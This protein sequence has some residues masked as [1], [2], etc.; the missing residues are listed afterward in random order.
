MIK[1]KKIKV[2]KD[3]Y[4]WIIV[5]KKKLVIIIDP[6]ESELL[7]SYL[8][9]KKYFPVAVFLTHK[10]LDHTA[11]VLDLLKKF[12]KLTIYG[13]KEIN[14]LKFIN[15]VEENK[16]INLFDRKWKVIHTPGHTIGHISY[17]SDPFLFCGDVLFSGGCGKVDDKNYLFLFNSIKKISFLPGET[18][19]YSSHEYTVKNLKFSHSLLK[20]D[21]KINFYYKKIK[22][23]N[24][25]TFC[26][27][28]TKL[29]F[30]KKINIF[31][32]TEEKKIK[33]SINLPFS[34]SSFECF[35][36]LRIL[37]DY[38]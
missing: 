23:Y 13:P 15:Y 34:S 37:K 19:I 18:L 32:R 12:P 28:P 25:K 17:Y 27:L 11:G 9:E 6:G 7:I 29:K 8:K 24:K 2:L 10:H 35:T 26:S 36:K 20:N 1:I 14:N 16:E 38:F 33:N 5:N 4:I 22:K 30:E 21:K 31:L 3:N